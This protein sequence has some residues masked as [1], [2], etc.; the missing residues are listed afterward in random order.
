DEPL[1]WAGGCPPSSLL[2]AYGLG[3]LP[4]ATVER[5]ASHLSDC[6]RCDTWLH[7]SP[8]EEDSLIANLRRCAL[9]GLPTGGL[10]Q[11]T[12]EAQPTVPDA[13]AICGTAAAGLPARLGQYELLE[14]LGRGGNGVVFKA[15]QVPLNR[16][17]ALKV[18]L[19]G[20]VPGTE[21]FARS[22]I[23]IAAVA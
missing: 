1:R 13:D 21:A 9:G 23:E 19:C 20:P 11:A 7:E 12:P 16:V 10:E 14:Q 6:K 18:S 8:E 17:V 15:R 5:V 4:P 22:Q 3:K 2:A